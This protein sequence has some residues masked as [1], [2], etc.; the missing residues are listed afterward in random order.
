MVFQPRFPRPLT[1]ALPYCAC[2]CAL[3]ALSCSAPSKGALILEISTNM[4]APKD[5][6]VVSL[7]V[8][9][10]SVPKFDYLGR[11]RPQGTVDL[12]STL[13]IVEPDQQG[14]SSFTLSPSAALVMS[15]LNNIQPITFVF[16][17]GSST[18]QQIYVVNGAGQ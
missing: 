4:Q 15:C 12:P 16:P 2:T 18:P 11:V 1:R 5:I 7:Y 10:D 8:E 9:T 17:Q 14:H 13:A 3:A 6:D